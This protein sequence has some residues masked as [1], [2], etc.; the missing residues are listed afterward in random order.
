MENSTQLKWF[1]SI[2]V[3]RWWDK[4]NWNS[5][6]N[7]YISISDLQKDSKEEYIKA[8]YNLEYGSWSHP[9]FV[10]RDQLKELW[11]NLE[12]YKIQENDHWYWLQ[13]EMKNFA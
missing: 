6:F 5:Y 13:K 8:K 11:Y 12:D 3:K 1:I 9:F 10:A 7:Y 2:H 4:I